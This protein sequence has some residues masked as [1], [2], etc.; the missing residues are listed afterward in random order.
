MKVVAWDSSIDM[1]IVTEEILPGDDTIEIPEILFE[2][3]TRNML[4][5]ARVANKIREFKKEQ[6]RER[7]DDENNAPKVL[8][9]KI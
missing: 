2:D 6:E 7:F 9:Y 3:Y 5:L 8:K 1:L 4:S